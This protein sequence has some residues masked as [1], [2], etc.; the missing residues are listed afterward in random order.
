M[1]DS[2]PEKEHHHLN[3]DDFV[4]TSE[5]RPDDDHR[6]ADMVYSPPSQQQP[7]IVVGGREEITFGRGG[8][9]TVKIGKR[10]RQI[11][12]L[13]ARI[14]YDRTNKEFKLV[15]LGLNGL[16]VDDVPYK[17]HDIVTLRDESLIDI[18]GCRIV[19]MCPEESVLEDEPTP[20]AD[21]SPERP[22]SPAPEEPPAQNDEPPAK[23][24]EQQKEEE[25]EDKEKEEKPDNKQTSITETNFT[26]I[27]IDTLG[28][29]HAKSLY[30]C[31]YLKYKFYSV[32]KEI[33][34]DS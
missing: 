3:S 6:I 31:I 27:I 32:F 23:S 22:L 8:A 12:R 30:I 16:S 9:A 26:D 18:L 21:L 24:E 33:I 19:F 13:H 2:P 25:G 28:I 4:R 34:H 15:V 7:L 20:Q 10:N 29:R 17:Q 1:P 5:I 11:S 14:E